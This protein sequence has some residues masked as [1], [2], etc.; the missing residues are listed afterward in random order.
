MPS[1]SRIAVA[2]IQPEA[3]RRCI[4][5][6]LAGALE[7]AGMHVQPFLARACFAAS[8]ASDASGQA[9]RH[10]DSWLMSRQVCEELFVY[11][12]RSADLALVEGGLSPRGMLDALYR[13][14]EV[15]ERSGPRLETLCRW[16][17]LPLIA[18]LDVSRIDGCAM[19]PRPPGLSG[20]LLDRAASLREMC[21]WRTLLESLWDTPVLGGLEE[22][23]QLRSLVESAD[24]SSPPQCALRAMADRLA[25]NLDLP[26]LLRLAQRPPR[27]APAERAPLGFSCSQAE[28]GA[29]MSP[30]A[31]VKIAVAYDDAFNCY[32]PDTLDLLE[33][34]G[35]T[36]CDF[37]PLRD[38]SLP[39]DVDIVYLGCGHPERFADPLAENHCMK[40]ALRSHVEAGG[41]VYAEGGGLAYLCQQLVLP[42]GRRLP[43][44][45]ALPAVA[46]RTPHP[47]PPQP[48]EVT[49]DSNCWLAKRGARLR[50]YLNTNWRLTPVSSLTSL[51]RE[52]ALRTSLVS[53]RGV[54]GSRLHLHFAAHPAF[55]RRFL[56]PTPLAAAAR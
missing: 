52:E 2:T 7:Q 47:Q 11:G 26:L 24:G 3:D 25:D 31:S 32:F 41:R 34:R 45:G 13:V 40:Q 43:M 46:V 6:A 15:E 28:Y 36:L 49:L 4:A 53:R 33:A 22:A 17:D 8:G 12:A 50:G 27:S 48:V 9:P 10:L 23:R 21:R 37:S 29:G 54:I 30:E 55:L 39:P 18:V 19:P 20:V 35:A 1:P 38:E 16:L 44:V 42:G 51:A 5:G 56:H 14:R